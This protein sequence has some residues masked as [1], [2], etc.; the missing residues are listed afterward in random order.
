MIQFAQ[1]TIN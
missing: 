1:I